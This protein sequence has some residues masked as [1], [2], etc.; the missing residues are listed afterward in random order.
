M[1]RKRKRPFPRIV[2][3]IEA[4]AER[5]P[6]LDV[7]P[8]AAVPFGELRGERS[9]LCVVPAHKPSAAPERHRP[10]VVQRLVTLILGILAENSHRRAAHIFVDPFV[11]CA[12]RAPP[13]MP[14]VVL[15]HEIGIELPVRDE[16]ERLPLSRRRQFHGATAT[17][18]KINGACFWAQ[19]ISHI[20]AQSRFH[21]VHAPTVLVLSYPP[22]I[23]PTTTQPSF[24]SNPR[25][26]RFRH[27]H[28]PSVILQLQPLLNHNPTMRGR[29]A[30]TLMC[31]WPEGSDPRRYATALCLRHKVRQRT[32]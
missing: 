32:T 20:I 15:L 17:A 24:V 30:A 1:A 27:N 23:P 5:P 19:L 6:R 16:H 4:E 9:A 26:T 12:K 22:S 2:R 25:T 8:A 3:G 28:P 21:L 11:V 18:H 13:R 31:H 7:F 14:A 29:S 10:R